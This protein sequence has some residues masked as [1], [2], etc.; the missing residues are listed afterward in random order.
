MNTADVESARVLK[1]HVMQPLNYSSFL[2]D[3][4]QERPPQAQLGA[5]GAFHGQ[6]CIFFGFVFTSCSA[7]ARMPFHDWLD[8]FL[9]RL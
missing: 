9:C 2:C 1:L 8:A 7:R 4:P 5:I 3:D 6:V